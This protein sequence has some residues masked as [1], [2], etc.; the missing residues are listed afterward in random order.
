MATST[1]REGAI[2]GLSGLA[3][4]WRSVR[5]SILGLQPLLSRAASSPR[6]LGSA[7]SASARVRSAR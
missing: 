7:L 3:I 4:A 5:A 1:A 2:A 6:A